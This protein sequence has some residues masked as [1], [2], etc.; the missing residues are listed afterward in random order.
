MEITDLK[1]YVLSI[2]S[3]HGIHDYDIKKGGFLAI[4]NDENCLPRT[5]RKVK[6]IEILRVEVKDEGT[7]IEL[8]V[9]DVKPLVTFLGDPD[10]VWENQKLT[11]IFEPTPPPTTIPYLINSMFRVGDYQFWEDEKTSQLW[12]RK[13][14]YVSGNHGNWEKTG[15]FSNDFRRNG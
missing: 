1:Q 8:L 14:D 10:E 5:T 15:I 11:A 13:F 4:K 12:K 6:I 3:I 2:E 9:E 7:S